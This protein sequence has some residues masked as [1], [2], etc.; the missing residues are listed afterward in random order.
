[1]DKDEFYAQAA[2]A[3]MQGFMES[4]IKIQNVL[5]FVPKELAVLSFNIADAML[6]EY[7]K[8]KKA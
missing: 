7:E 6:E 3:A 5:D 4:G 8:R 1:M 2:I